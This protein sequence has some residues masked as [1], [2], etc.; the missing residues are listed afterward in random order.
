MKRYELYL[1]NLDPTIGIEMKKTRPCLIIS[2]DEMNRHV[3]TLIVAP[4]TTIDDLDLTL[5]KTD[6]LPKFVKASV[7]S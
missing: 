3:Q 2:P 7:E 4:L 6:Y 5:F 1:V